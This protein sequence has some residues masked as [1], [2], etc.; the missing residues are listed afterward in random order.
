MILT[1]EPPLAERTP[2]AA[3]WRSWE[4]GE[5]PFTEILPVGQRRPSLISFPIYFK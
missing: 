4:A 1:L 3:E 5:K 2:L